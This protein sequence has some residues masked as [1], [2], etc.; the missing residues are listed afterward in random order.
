MIINQFTEYLKKE[1]ESNEPLFLALHLWTHIHGIL[2]IYILNRM[3]FE[4]F[5]KFYK[6]SISKLLNN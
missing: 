3:Y 4:D 2:S 5:D 6:D 1:R